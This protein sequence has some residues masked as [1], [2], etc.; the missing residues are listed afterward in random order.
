MRLLRVRNNCEWLSTAF[1]S[2]FELIEAFCP[3]T[4]AAVSTKLTDGSLEVSLEDLPRSSGNSAR[5]NIIK[6]DVSVKTEDVGTRIKEHC[7]PT[8]TRE[9][10]EI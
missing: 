2:A 7:T 6:E 4:E 8:K 5:Q 10:K 9:R 3:V 1:C